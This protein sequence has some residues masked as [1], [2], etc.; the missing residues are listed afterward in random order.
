ML[1]MTEMI[2]TYDSFLLFYSFQMFAPK[3]LVFLDEK[4]EEVKLDT[5]VG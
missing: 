5:R 1:D 3:M 4:L 2:V